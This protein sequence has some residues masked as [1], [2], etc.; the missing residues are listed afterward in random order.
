MS[1][2]SRSSI[3]EWW[4]RKERRVPVAQLVVEDFQ[5]SGFLVLYRGGDGGTSS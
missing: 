4:S 1:S 2:G 3:V 5:R